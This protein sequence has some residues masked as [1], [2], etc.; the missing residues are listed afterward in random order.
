MLFGPVD[1]THWKTFSPSEALDENELLDDWPLDVRRSGCGCYTPC[2]SSKPSS[3][4]EILSLGAT[5]SSLFLSETSSG[6][7]F[8]DRNLAFLVRALM[9]NC[10]LRNEYSVRLIITQFEQEVTEWCAILFQLFVARCFTE[11]SVDFCYTQN[12]C[13]NYNP[14]CSVPNRHLNISMR[15]RKSVTS[16]CGQ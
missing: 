5:A 6:I 1:L 2:S 9:T 14:K 11:Q 13:W 12:F 10:W 15:V 3:S 8:G 7:R 16:Q 4:Y